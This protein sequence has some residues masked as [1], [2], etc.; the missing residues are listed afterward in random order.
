[1]DSFALELKK[2]I[3]DKKI[4]DRCIFHVS[5]E[6]AKKFLKQ[7]KKASDI[8][9]R[10]FGDFPIVDAMS[11]YE[12]F[13]NGLIQLPIPSNDHIEKFIGNVD[14]LWTYYC[15]AQYTKYVSNRF[16]NMPSQRNRILGFQLY[17]YDAKGFLHWGYN[18]WYTRFSIKEI[19]PYKV[20]DAGGAFAAG[21]SFV[22]YPGADGKPLASLR[23]KVFYD[24]LQDMRALQLLESLTSRD[25]ALSLIEEDGQ[26][27]FSQYPHSDDWQLKTR[28][29]IN[30]EIAKAS[31]K[32]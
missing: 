8:V 28:Q 27:T 5:D 12:F 2:F 30:S 29:K 31:K 15:C 4:A 10:N 26:I 14:K 20:T 3:A 9:R 7:Y 17:K 24:A 21:D 1:M 13:G 23:L 22:V 18:Y 19:D 16:F 32:K 6:P 25:F 11:D